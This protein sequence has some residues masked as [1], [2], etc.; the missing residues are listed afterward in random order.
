MVGKDYIE[1][2]VVAECH[3]LLTDKNIEKIAKE[4][5]A[6]CE[7]EKDTTNLRRLKKELSENERKHKNLMNAVMECDNESFRKSLYL[8]A[9]ELE[10]EHARIEKEIAL[11]E[12]NYPS[13]TVPK[14]K[15]FLNALRKGDMTESRHRKTLIAVFVNAIYL[16]D[17]KITF[18]FNSG[19]NPVTI[20]DLL[21]SEIEAGHKQDNLCLCPGLYYHVSCHTILRFGRETQT[22]VR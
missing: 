10:Q 9:P 21:L 5:V 11:E 12:K 16:Y 14:V 7:A 17:D 22:F 4:V 18:I 8:Q 6:V 2:L 15:F 13:L 3:K 19:E 1:D 20:N